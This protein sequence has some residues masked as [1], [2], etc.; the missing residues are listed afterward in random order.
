MKYRIQARGTHL[1][2]ELTGRESSHDMREFLLAVKDAC[3][4]NACPRILL[5]IKDSRAMF[6]AEDYGLTG[7]MGGYVSEMITPSCRIALIGDSS[8][9]NYAHEYI[10][11]VARQQQVNV[12]AFRTAA[13]AIQWLEEA[14]PPAPD[15][16]ALQPARAPKLH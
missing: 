10:E 3:L 9:L 7:Q 4:H 13:S 11:V 16:D 5:S 14:G 1:Y 6:K 15:L 12:R 2:A 8:D